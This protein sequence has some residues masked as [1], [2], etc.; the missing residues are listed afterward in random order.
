MRRIKGNSSIYWSSGIGEKK[1]WI[2]QK[3]FKHFEIYFQKIADVLTA[4]SIHLL[5][6]NIQHLNLY[7]HGHF[8]GVY[9]FM[10]LICIHISDTC[11]CV[12][13]YICCKIHLF[14][15]LCFVLCL[16]IAYI[17]FLSEHDFHSFM[18]YFLWCKL[19]KALSLPG[20]QVELRPPVWCAL[21]HFSQTLGRDPFVGRR[22]VFMGPFFVAYILFLII[23]NISTKTSKSWIDYK[24][25]ITKIFLFSNFMKK[26]RNSL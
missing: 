13:F 16:Y 12:T 24:I 23:I 15:R 21:N 5:C 20:S 22:H 7:W 17:M 9:G 14:I 25:L 8:P 2:I 10:Y 4:S 1:I 3:P 6:L 26:S 18:L 19:C 11:V